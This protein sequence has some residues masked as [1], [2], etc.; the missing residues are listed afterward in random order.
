MRSKVS[1]LFRAT[2]GAD[3]IAQTVVARFL[4]AGMN[5]ATGIISAR[6]LGA[7]GRGEMSAMLVWPMLLAYLLTLGL[8][9]ALR[10]WIRREP[11][12]RAE[13]FTTAVAG[14]ALSSLVAVAIGV[15]F[16]PRWLHAY[17]PDIVRAAQ[18]VMFFSPEVML[19]LIT[20]AMLE[21]LG[22]F[23][24]AN[25]TRYAMVGFT[26][27]G[28]AI[29]AAGHWM[30]PFSG[31]LAYVCAPV[32]VALWTLWKLRAHLRFR[33]FDPRPAARLLG[34]YAVRSYVIDLMNVIATQIDTV[35]VIAFLSPADVGIYAVAL[36]ASRVIN[37]LH[38]SVAAV[39]FP[40][41]TGH[42]SRI[43]VAMVERAARVSTAIALPFGAALALALPV[44]LPLF[45]GTAFARGIAV[46]QVL[47]LEAVVSGLIAVLAQAF[48]ALGRPGSVTMLQSLGLAAVVPL[49]FLLLP[50][51]GLIGAAYALLISSA[52]RLA[53]I[54]AM[55]PFVLHA[56]LPKLIPLRE[57]FVRLRAI[58]A[59]R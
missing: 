28:L 52:L 20:T 50:H 45:Y 3:A 44:L 27:L 16:I 18:I 43:V 8:P 6:T 42:D 59:D 2:R 57:D 4:T 21:T 9:A 41:A 15:T 29:L 55:Y 35:L 5:V 24:S 32:V 37:I 25:A 51:F 22:D 47:T 12:R 48:M 14:A 19:S 36:N 11:E 56:K 53:L 23:Y 1:F 33:V 30:T 58:L 38:Q 54:L 26:L 13:L 7:N 31:A 49:M 46:G 17:P 34:S 39:I 10:Y 40:E